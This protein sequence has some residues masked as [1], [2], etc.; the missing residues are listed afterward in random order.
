MDPD[1]SG[2]WEAIAHKFIATRSNIGTDVVRRWSKLLV[3]CGTV[4]DLG[5]GS[6]API[7]EMLDATGFQVYGVDA[8]STLISAFR[9]RFPAAEAACETVEGSGFFNRMFDGAVAVGLMFLLPEESQRRVIDRVGAALK[10]GG[11]FLFSAPRPACKWNDS[12]T[13]GLSSSLGTDEYQQTIEN[14]GMRFVGTYED[15][16]KNNYFDA[17]KTAA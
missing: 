8:S 3:P 9:R 4:V 1:L 17:T 11:R 2:G 14:A 5:C 10:P 13:G 16:G 15:E 6:G 7:S 12:L